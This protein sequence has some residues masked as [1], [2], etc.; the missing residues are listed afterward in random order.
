[1]RLPRF[2]LRRALL[3][4][5]LLLLAAG[6]AAPF[7]RAGQFEARIR[8]T[9]EQS[10]GGRRVEMEDV[11]FSLFRGP[12]FSLRKVVI[13]EDPA[14]GIEP[15]AYV[16]SI[17]ARLR[18]R[19]LWTGRLEF[20]SLR[21]AQPSVNLVKPGVGPW[22]FQVLLGRASGGELPEI[23]VRGGRIN[24]KFGD[25]K[26][27]FYFSDADLDIAAPS[28]SADRI[29]VSFSGEPARTDRT[30]L[31]FG[32]LAGNGLW[33]PDQGDG[34]RLRL[35]LRLE[36]SAIGELVALIHGQDVGVH[37]WMAAAAR[38]EGPLSDLNISGE[39]QLE[40]IHR[41]DLM[42]PYAQGGPL[43]FQGR[44]DLPSQ[45]LELETV[46]KENSALAVR[47]RASD[48]L[49]KPRWGFTLSL[50]ELSL[51][52][53]LEVARHMGSAIPD[54]VLAK[55]GI[56]GV[57]GYSPEEGFQ[58]TVNVPVAVIQAPSASPVRF[59]RAQIVLDGSQVRLVSAQVRSEPGEAAEVRADY[60]LTTRELDLRITVDELEIAKS[61]P[62]SG[63]L[64]GIV[65]VPFL[66]AF[67]GGSAAGTLRYRHSEK[68]AGNWQGT[69]DV[70]GAS[71]SVP[72]LAEP[73]E[74]T[75]ARLQL[76]PTGFIV[77]NASGRIGGAEAAAELRFDAVAKRPAH[78]ECRILEIDGEELERILMPALRRERG[79]LSRTLGLG[80]VPVPLWM[81]ER[82]SQG[83]L[84]IRSFHVAGLRVERMKA[85]VFW[86][87]AKLHI[88]DFTAS[89]RNGSV[90]GHMTVDLQGAEPV[91][92]VNAAVRGMRWKDGVL[93]WDTRIRMRSAGT[94]L[95]ASL[96][97][98]GSFDGRSLALDPEA[99]LRRIAG[100][101]EMTWRKGVPAVN[102]RDVRAV[103]SKG[104]FVG[105]GA[106]Q[107][108]GQ[109]RLDLAGEDEH[110]TL[111]VS[112]IK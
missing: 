78:W 70:K 20:S 6:V 56:A 2:T 101:Y 5:L 53:V 94:A 36:R 100:D 64:L 69:L 73:F 33:R 98:E 77:T 4:V 66:G 45:H 55:G 88:T 92:E 74:L 1:M 47:F 31:A 52:P 84:E 65:R 95:G 90:N 102:L 22:N 54:G 10:L 41:W 87:Q 40:E 76:R 14:I 81:Q 109:V 82:R 97:A 44:L 9:L 30:S 79:F 49:S 32:K 29:A 96:R 17:D 3:A 28:A 83:I 80:R 93:N 68:T 39:A 11:R 51:Q 34:G 62:G 21:M 72:G 104:V 27:V 42:P 25:I 15:F 61:P 112:L 24:F 19:S 35:D 48:Y 58:G 71:V 12:G 7:F 13:G 50:K 110:L 16:D 8:E 43:R 99:R 60:S 105:S 86:D 85:R 26:S 38:L 111:P 23:H 106:S 18:L 57:I 37:G 108:D 67:R 103:T 75:A 59:E 63:L 46:E 89:L 107:P 91:Y